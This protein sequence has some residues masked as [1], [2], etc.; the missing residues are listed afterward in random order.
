MKIAI[1]GHTAG[2]GKELF[3]HYNSLGHTV[4][5]ISRS[6]GFDI[7]SGQDEIVTAISGYDLFINNTHHNNCQSELLDKTV[8][9]VCKQVVI[10]SALH[11]FRDIA[12]FNY[13]DQKFILSQK[14]RN[15]NINPNISTKILHVNISFLPNVEE[16][17]DRLVSDNVVQHKEVISLIDYWLDTPVLTDVVFQWK[18][19]PLVL[20]QLKRKIPELQVN[21]F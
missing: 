2:L 14:C 12:T 5:G 6:T 3:E 18:L 1:T 4:L 11:L 15:Y 19:T 21:L 16:D 7:V 20:E 17:S 9:K 13:L 10:G 8:N